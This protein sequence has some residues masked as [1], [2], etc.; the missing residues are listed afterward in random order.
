MTRD[1]KPSSKSARPAAKAAATTKPGA[2]TG[3]RP[4]GAR[5][6]TRSGKSTSDATP[7]TGS[8]GRDGKLHILPGSVR[9]P[10]TDSRPKPASRRRSDTETEQAAEAAQASAGAPTGRTSTGR[11]SASRSSA[12]SGSASASRP[13]ANGK[14]PNPPRQRGPQLDSP[15]SGATFRDRDGKTHSF[16]DSALKRI[17]AQVLTER[18]KRWRYRPFGFPIFSAS[19]SEQ[20]L[21]FDFY[22]YDNMDSIFKLIMLVPRESRELWDRVGRFKQQYPMYHYELWTPEHLAKIMGPNGKLGW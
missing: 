6:V 7:G 10:K 11:P 22:V 13:G 14:R 21:H 16:P 20:E 2:R 1:R 12:G 4:T 3:A 18:S 17:A 5:P 9:K 15:P 19:G 8:V